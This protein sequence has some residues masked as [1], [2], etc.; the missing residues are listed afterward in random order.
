MIVISMTIM[1]L[2][3]WLSDLQFDMLK[4]IHFHKIFKSLPERIGKS[5]IHS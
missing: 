1:S 4:M 2:K 3:I 5:K